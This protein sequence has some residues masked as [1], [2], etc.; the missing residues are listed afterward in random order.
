M[1]NQEPSAIIINHMFTGNYLEDNIGHE[2]INL[3]KADN[4]N[5]YIYLCKDGK[6]KR[7]SLPEYLVQVRRYG[8]RI[9]EIVNIAKIESLVSP[10]EIETITYGG[11][12]LVDVFSDNIEQGTDTYATFRASKVIKPKAG[13]HKTITYEG[14]RPRVNEISSH[15]APEVHFDEKRDD[16]KYCFDVGE[17]LRNYISY[18]TSPQSDYSKIQKLIEDAFEKSKDWI[19]VEE[20]VENVESKTE[21]VT[22][23]DIYAIENLE[24]PYSNAF[25]FFLNKYPQLLPGFCKFLLTECKDNV[26]LKELCNYFSARPNPALTIHREWNNID[27]LIEIDNKWVLVIENKIFSALNGR[28]D[29][30]ITQL[31]KY[32]DII[33]TSKKSGE[34]VY[35]LLTPDHNDIDITNYPHW[36]KLHY[37]QVAEYLS[38]VEDEI[39]DIHLKDFTEMVRRHSDRDY[40]YGL[41]KRRF[42]RVLKNH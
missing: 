12:H 41:M 34:K 9:L 11:V 20:K 13:L 16:G 27:I 1:A 23:G 40:N 15:I 39:D 5:H 29:S 6:Y 26:I 4:D 2:I 25:R 14:N 37:S 3:F 21:H 17:T 22:P 35:I 19:E 18:S 36:H 8:T 32:Y 30:E 38:S 28:K 24:L 7:K 10:E 33:S 31:N 42:E